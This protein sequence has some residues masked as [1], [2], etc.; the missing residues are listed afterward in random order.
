MKFILHVFL[1]MVINLIKKK[2]LLLWKLW[3]LWN[4]QNV[5]AQLGVPCNYLP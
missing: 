4:V 5:F 1:L 2:V 3:R